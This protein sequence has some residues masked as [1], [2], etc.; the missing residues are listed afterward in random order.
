MKKENI[1]FV[2]V[3]FICFLIVAFAI[4]NINKTER[5]TEY[6]KELCDGCEE[7]QL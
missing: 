1:H 5:S 3:G 6:K 2:I 4:S 7:C